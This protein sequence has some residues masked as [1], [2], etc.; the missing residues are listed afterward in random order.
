MH[1][2]RFF[3]CTILLAIVSS[4]G[5]SQSSVSTLIREGSR[6]INGVR[7]YYTSMGSGDPV[8]FI[9]GGPGLDH[10]YFLPQMSRLAD[11]HRLV[12]F[13][14]RASGRSGIP[15]DTAAMR[16]SRFVDDIEGIR[17]A[18]KL[19]HV[20]VLGHSWGTLLALR[21]A[22]KYP[23]HITSLVLVS[24]VP[25]SSA[26]QT[27][28]MQRV[29]ISKKDS[30]SL[31]S[32]MKTR[33]F[34]RRTPLAM[35][36]YFRLTFR[37]IMYKPSDAS[38]IRLWFPRNYAAR[39]RMLRYLGSEAISFDLYPRLDSLRVHTLIIAGDH[40]PTPPSV[41]NHLQ[42]SIP[43]A[44]LVVVRNCGHFPSIEQP[45]QFFRALRRFLK[46]Q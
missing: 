13:D 37:G 42:Q 11:S 27:L 43:D 46:N 17:K 21:Y 33:S 38:K 10:T 25:A 4:A 32:L 3:Q 39:S 41:L 30:V 28:A 20:T 40:D 35:E 29:H 45:K 24:P 8:L 16:I 23:K 2:R 7:L 6:R 22:L 1:M 12:F 36:R 14:Q 5:L 19:E 34:A 9:H 26:E 31:A 44:R 18:L 15:K